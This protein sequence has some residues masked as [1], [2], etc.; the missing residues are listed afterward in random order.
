MN[1]QWLYAKQP[2]GKIGKD[3]FEW[4]E[5]AI[6]QPRGFVMAGGSA[7]VDDMVRDTKRGVLVTRL[8]YIRMLDPQKLVLTGDKLLLVEH[9]QRLFPGASV[10]Y[11]KTKSETATQLERLIDVLVREALGETVK[12]VD[13][14]KLMGVE[15]RKVTKGLT[16]HSRFQT[17]VTAAGWQYVPGRGRR[18]SI[19]VRL[20]KHSDS[21]EAQ[22]Y[23]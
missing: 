19:F 4:R 11:T 1:R 15:W 13:V 10:S 16:G 20:A 2:Q 12:A 8:W 9:R 6:P 17:L 23:S 5:T 7:S 3:T 22:T 14:A 18:G 21:L